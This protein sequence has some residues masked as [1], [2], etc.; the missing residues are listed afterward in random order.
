MVIV[1]DT[2]DINRGGKLL[3]MKKL[4]MNFLLVMW[5]KLAPGTSNFSPH[6]LYYHDLRCFG[7][8]L[9]LLRFTHFCVEQK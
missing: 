9:I 4:H 2:A 3:Y 6:C 8:K 5:R 7:A 1:A